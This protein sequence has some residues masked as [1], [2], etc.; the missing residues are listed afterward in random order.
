MNKITP[1][2]YT[3]FDTCLRLGISRATLYREIRAG[4]LQACRARGR[5]LISGEAQVLWLESLPAITA[6]EGGVK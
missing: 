4:R 1:L 2:A 3:I 5:T 6:A